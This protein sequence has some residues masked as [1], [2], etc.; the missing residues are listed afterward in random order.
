MVDL[1]FV[2]KQF[3]RKNP[4]FLVCR[5]PG[6]EVIVL[7]VNQLKVVSIEC[8]YGVYDLCVE[9]STDIAKKN[10]VVCHKLDLRCQENASEGCILKKCS[11]VRLPQTP[12]ML[13][14]AGA[15]HLALLPI[16]CHL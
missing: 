8:E 14:A 10:Q 15:L 7:E 5:M 13:R 6:L 9:I 4:A 2:I 11:G 12:A 3:T 1:G 16:L